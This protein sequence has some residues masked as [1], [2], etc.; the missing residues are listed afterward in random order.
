MAAER[1]AMIMSSAAST[2]IIL[3]KTITQSCA[4]VDAPRF[5][6]EREGWCWFFGVIDHHVR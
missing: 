3:R 6:T 1:R 5:C 4:S 2:G